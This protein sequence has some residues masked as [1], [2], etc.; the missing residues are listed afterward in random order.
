VGGSKLHLPQKGKWRGSH[1]QGRLAKKVVL[2]LPS[3]LRFYSVGVGVKKKKK[4]F[5]PRRG[6]FGSLERKGG[7]EEG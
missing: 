5:P 6:D 7:P 1:G 3:N 2:Q 4:F